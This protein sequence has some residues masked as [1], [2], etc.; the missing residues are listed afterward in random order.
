MPKKGGK[1]KD[2]KKAAK[3]AAKQQALQAEKARCAPA[4]QLCRRS[5]RFLSLTSA[6]AC[7][8]RRETLRLAMAAEDPLAALPG[9]FTAFNRNGV[10]G[11]FEHHRGDALPPADLSTLNRMM[12]AHGAD[13]GRQRQLAEDDA[14]LLLLRVSSGDGAAAAPPSPAAS[15]VKEKEEEKETEELK[16]GSIAAFAHYRFVVQD[17]AL[18][19]RIHE[20]H[21]DPAARRKGVGKMVTM[22]CEMLAKK[23]GM[24]G[25]VLSL[26]RE[27]SDALAFFTAI[28][29]AVDPLSPSRIDPTS[30]QE[31]PEI[32]SKLWDDGVRKATE[33][34]GA[35]A[36][37]RNAKGEAGGKQKDMVSASQANQPFLCAGYC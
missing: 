1:A 32:Y 16:P 9:A 8:S 11:A 17:D 6:H 30:E 2:A 15:P 26:P 35:E 24:G 4:Q 19:L 34:R 13:G 5:E 3:K 20:L 7:V 23:A 21:V 36:A 29:F 10:S 18:L 14:R 37:A 25:A 12:R 33:Q 28:K 27:A 22:L 31:K